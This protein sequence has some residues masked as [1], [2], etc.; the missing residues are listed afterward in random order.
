MS[1]VSDL[2]FALLN[3][4]E[5]L[6]L[7]AYP[8]SGGVWTIGYGHIKGVKEGDVCTLAQARL[9][10]EEDLEPV[11]VTI[12][13]YLPGASIIAQAVYASFGYNCGVTAL[14]HIL[15]GKA[16]MTEFIHVGNL[17]S[18]GLLSRRALEQALIDASVQY[19]PGE[20]NDSK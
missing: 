19:I 11:Y 4:F 12:Q 5:G 13:H 9:W 20:E 10:M 2:T 8:D 16:K 17:V 15:E 3:V 7:H 6:R 18:N 1:Q 14:I